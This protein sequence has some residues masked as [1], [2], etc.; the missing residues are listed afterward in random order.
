MIVDGLRMLVKGVSLYAIA[1]FDALVD[2]REAR[3][4][5]DLLASFDDRMLDDIG[6]TACDVDRLRRGE[7]LPKDQ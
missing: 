6:L 4:N 1:L 7:S 5:A 3:R 2:G